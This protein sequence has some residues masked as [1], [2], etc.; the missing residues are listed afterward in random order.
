VLL[1]ICFYTVLGGMGVIERDVS[2]GMFVTNLVVFE[3]IGQ[4]WGTI[5]KALLDMQTVMP[6]LR[7][8][9]H[10]LNLPTDVPERMKLNRL[11]RCET[12]DS[13]AALRAEAEKSNV[14]PIDVLPIC[15]KDT[16]VK[17]RT[18][19]TKDVNRAGSKS[20][21]VLSISS[22]P[23][24][25]T[26]VSHVGKLELYQGEFVSL[27]GPRSDGKSTLLKIIGGVILPDGGQVFVPSHLRVLHI[28]AAPLFFV[29]SLLQNL[30]LG[31]AVGDSDGDM[32]RVNT[33]CE[34]LGLAR[35]V[36]NY[37]ISQ[38]VFAWG[39]M[40]SQ[41]QRHLLSLARALVA[42][43]ELL[44]IHKPTLVFDEITSVM[45]LELLKEFVMKK[46]IEQNPGT[47][48]LRRP[49]TCIITS[50]KMK[51]VDVADRIFCISCSNGIQHLTK[52]K[53][54]A[55]LLA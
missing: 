32:E 25:I 35:T 7:R 51:D 21:S 11:R 4:A 44:C 13:R 43:P 42:N 49:R 39:E 41:T 38:E 27:V 50:C 17:Y 14:L 40:L 47:K 29:G 12:R 23:L 28:S 19:K 46:G 22:L 33:I 26:S 45:V 1:F 48:Q 52:D 16:K 8:I 20:G 5:Y 2:L 24:R 3:Q 55:D 53:V 36:R 18:T 31:V 15:L 6:A 54:S 9:V 10:L 37:V 34:R 30:T